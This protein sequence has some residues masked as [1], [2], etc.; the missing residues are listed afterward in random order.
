MRHSE[1]ICP[2]CSESKDIGFFQCDGIGIDILK[3]Y[4]ELIFFSLFILPLPITIPA[5]LR[6]PCKNIKMHRRHTFRKCK[7]CHLI[8]NGS[9]FMTRELRKNIRMNIENSITAPGT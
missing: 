5:M 6:K 3:E 8:W 7:N 9:Y 1:N 2:N 4:L